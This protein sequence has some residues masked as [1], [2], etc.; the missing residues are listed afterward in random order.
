MKTIKK[1]TFAMLTLVAFSFTFTS[2]DAISDALSKEVDMDAPTID[3]SIGGEAAVNAP[4]QKVSGATEVIW[5]EK[6]VDLKTRIQEELDK[7][8]LKTDNVKKLELIASIIKVSSTINK[9]YDLGNIKLYVNDELIANG[10]GSIAS[11]ATQFVLT[12]NS[13][14][15]VLSFL[16]TGTY[17][18]KI[19]SDKPKPTEKLDMQLLNTYKGKFSLL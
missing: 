19:T 17:K 9:N 2:C 13:P 16:N 4:Q 11:T 1:F 10:I 18:I 6:S 3:F 7:S 15:S 8:S 5:L 14:Y 12:Y